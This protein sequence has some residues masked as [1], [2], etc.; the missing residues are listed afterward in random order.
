MFDKVLIANRGEVALRIHR[1]CREMG[2]R[3]V[4]VHSEVDTNAM[5]VRLADESVCIGP[6]PARDSYLNVPAIL[7]AAEITGADAIHPGYGFLSENSRFAEIIEE[8]G[9]TFIGPGSEHIRL[10]G[11]KMAARN[12]ARDLGIPVLPGSDG[13]VRDAVE[14]AAIAREIGYPVLL[15]AA[16]GGGGRGI[17]LVEDD[18]NMEAIFARSRRESEAAFGD[19]SL[20]V[21][22]FLANPRHIEIQVAGDLEGRVV[23]LGER[24]C[25]VQRRHQKIVE[26]A[27]SPALNAGQRLA[28]GELVVDAMVRLGYRN[29]GTVEFLYEDGL[30]HFIEMNTRL[31]VEHPVTEMVTGID[32]VREQICLSSGAPLSFSQDD[33]TMTGHAIECRINAESPFSFMPSPGQVTTYH[34]PGGMSVRIDSALYSGYTVPPTYDNLIAKLVVCGRNRNE[35]MMRLRRALEEFA[36]DGIETTIPLHQALL[37]NQDFANGHYDVTWLERFLACAT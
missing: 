23:H 5:H 26:E 10:M 34:A 30:F 19:G 7:A 8:H 37:G 33:V 11:D 9:I 15:K 21:E 27:P 16:S 22:K 4:A 3:T 31:Q 14:A 20:Y 25:S 28:I 17:S 18:S 29:L 32:L 1:A 36:I 35:S 2:I 24:D 6:A 12:K 13:V